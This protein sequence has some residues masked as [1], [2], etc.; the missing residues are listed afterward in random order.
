ML[1]ERLQFS[2][3]LQFIIFLITEDRTVGMTSLGEHL[4]WEK[5]N[6]TDDVDTAVVGI[7][8]DTSLRSG[9]VVSVATSLSVSLPSTLVNCAG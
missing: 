2:E 3:E 9:V 8:Y 4:G 1:A 6:Y 5:T 7:N